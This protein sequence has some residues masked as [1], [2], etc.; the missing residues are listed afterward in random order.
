MKV[1]IVHDFLNQRGG[2]ERMVL[3]TARLFPDAPIYT[4]L[5]DP[6]GTFDEFRDMD[7]RT[8]FLQRFPHSEK[9][10]RFLLPLYP[11]AFR[12]M[13]LT[14]F[15]LVI[16]STTHWAHHVRPGSSAHHVIYC[17]NPPRWLYQ[18]KRYVGEGGPIPTWAAIPLAPLLFLLRLLDQRAAAR[19]D[20]YI[21]NS[22]LVAERIQS[23]YSRVAEVVNPPIDIHLFDAA[24]ERRKRSGIG[25]DYYL[26]V[27]RLLPYKRVDLAVEVCT[28]RGVPLVVVGEGPA[29]K[30]LEHQA[31]PNVRFTGK[32]GDD[33]L[34]GLYAGARALIHSG[35]EDFGLTPLEANAAGIPCVAIRN[36]GALETV[37]TGET[38][39]LFPKQGGEE[40]NAA[41]DVLESRRWDPSTLRAHAARFQEAN[42]QLRLL[43]AISASL[44]RRM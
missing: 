12:R 38:G 31:G 34:A 43:N 32:V 26:V 33:E 23:T 2:A 18:T 30:N 19:P 39:I 4:S 5:Y 15:D 40:L 16:S 9:S 27:S 13:K 8:T 3:S 20:A 28:K 41:L 29:R 10:F 7:V 35:E 36:G 17:H 6:D 24:Y 25:G 14:Q 42:F 44:G 21:C 37:I 11:L 1:A 22:N